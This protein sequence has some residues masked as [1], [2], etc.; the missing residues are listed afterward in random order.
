MFGKIALFWVKL[1]YFWRKMNYK[2]IDQTLNI[3]SLRRFLTRQESILLFL[4]ITLALTVLMV[5]FGQPTSLTEF[6]EQRTPISPLGQISISFVSG[7]VVLTISR[8]LLYIVNWRHEVQP[9]AC[10]VWLIVEMLLCVTVIS[11]VF[12]AISGAGKVQLAALV[13]DIVLGFLGVQLVPYVISFLVY[14]LIEDRVE[15]ARLRQVIEKHDASLLPPVDSTVN[16]YAKGGRLAFS[17]KM[18]NVLF[19]ESADNYVNI[20]YLNEDKE[21]TFILHN[22]LKEIE[23]RFA[24][25]SLI[26]CHRGYM[27]NVENVKLMRKESL[28]LV[29]E[30]NQSTKVIPV[31][32]SYAGSVTRFFAS[33]TDIPLPGD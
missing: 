20:H 17:T 4:A 29:L 2:Y 22:T 7:F 31:S 14:R 8:E 15:I 28:G 30:L 23:K 19:L 33:G 27:V 32:K 25:S 6:T 12:W 26:R 10:G 11:L 21:D 16:F 13:G 24:D 5:V 3:G 9:A 1:Y 18:S